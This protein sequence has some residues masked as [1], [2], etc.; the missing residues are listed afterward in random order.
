MRIGKRFGAYQK[1]VKVSEDGYVCFILP[2]SC[3]FNNGIVSTGELYDFF[4]VSHETGKRVKGRVSIK[5]ADVIAGNQVA[6]GSVVIF[7]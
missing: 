3:Y 5:E 1:E 2:Y 4:I 6:T 7:K